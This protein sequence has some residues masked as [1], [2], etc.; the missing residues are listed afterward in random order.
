[1]AKGQSLNRRGAEN[2][3]E[4]QWNLA[5]DKRSSKFPYLREW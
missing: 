4:K 1:M 5:A 3:E 2:A